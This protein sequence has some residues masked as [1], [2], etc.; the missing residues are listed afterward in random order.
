MIE[1][2]ELPGLEESENWGNE[3]RREFKKGREIVG[4]D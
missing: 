4:A 1:I 2:G 3:I